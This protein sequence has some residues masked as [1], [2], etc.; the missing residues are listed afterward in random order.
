VTPPVF[1]PPRLPRWLRALLVVPLLLFGLASVAFPPIIV[2]GLIRRGLATGRPAST[3]L[4]VLIGALWL[5]ILVL[6]LRSAVRA[7]R[8]SPASGR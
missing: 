5:L 7:R 4:G 6:L 1:A 8:S 2:V 3:T